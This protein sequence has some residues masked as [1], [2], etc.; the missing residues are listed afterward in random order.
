MPIIHKV[1]FGASNA[2]FIISA[3]SLGLVMQELSSDVALIGN[4]Q[5]QVVLAALQVISECCP[6]V[7]LVIL[8][9]T[10]SISLVTS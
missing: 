4:R 6:L 8:R 2:M 9:E 3:I 5:A 1:L 7:G 10:R